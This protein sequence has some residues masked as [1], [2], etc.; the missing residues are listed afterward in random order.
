MVYK[1]FPKKPFVEIDGYGMDG[2]DL[3]VM[4]D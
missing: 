3:I 2:F 4:L 1:E